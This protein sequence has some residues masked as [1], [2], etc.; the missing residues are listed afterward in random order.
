MKNDE[1][2]F[3]EIYTNIRKFLSTL[4][5][6]PLKAE[7]S[8]FL[9]ELGF[10]KDRLINI[11]IRSGILMRKESINVDDVDGKKCVKHTIGY[12]V[13]RENFDD[14]IKKIYTAFFNDYKET[15][16]V[17]ECDCGGATSAAAVDA[18]APIGPIGQPIF[19]PSLLAYRE[20]KNKKDKNAIDPTEIRGKTLRCENKSPRRFIMT[21]EQVNRVVGNCDFV[22]EDCSMAYDSPKAISVKKTD[23]S[24][25]KM[26]R[27]PQ[28][29][30]NSL[31]GK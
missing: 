11:L 28:N 25:T 2:T 24:L 3:F 29:D 18:C 14:N 20:K 30:I 31:F 1:I 6:S 26:G 4:L 17:M 9:V 23:K 5:K 8:T 12:S 13:K 16:E 10:G 22:E 21:Q 19:Q 7:P 15:D 27:S